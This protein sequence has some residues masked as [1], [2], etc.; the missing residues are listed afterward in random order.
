[1][2]G[3]VLDVLCKLP[4][5]KL[6]IFQHLFYVGAQLVVCTKHEFPALK[7]IRVYADCP[8]GQYPEV[9]QFEEGSMKVL[10]KLSVNFSHWT[11]KRI[12][13][14]KHLK[15]LKEVRLAGTKY[16]PALSRALEE[17]EKERNSRSDPSRFKVTVSYDHGYN[18]I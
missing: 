9:I 18:T 15:N 11:S 13:G 14:I 6:I 17:L 16:N 12:A 1:M 2:D 10:E 7:E 8:A 5:L 4:N 3:Q